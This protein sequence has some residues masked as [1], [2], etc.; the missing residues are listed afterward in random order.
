MEKNEKYVAYNAAIFAT[1]GFRKS[2]LF[3]KS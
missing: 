3:S 2:V 1:I